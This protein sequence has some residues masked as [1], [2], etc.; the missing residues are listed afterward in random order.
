MSRILEGSFRGLPL[1][2]LDLAA[3]RAVSSNDELHH[4]SEARR[5]RRQA[6][7]SS[8][9]NVLGRWNET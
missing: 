5:S 4:V 2:F 1:V 6:R 9:S 3:L 8:G 7:T